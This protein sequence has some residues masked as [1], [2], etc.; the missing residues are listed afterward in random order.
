MEIPS[1]N[2]LIEQSIIKNWE[3]DALTDYKGATLQ[4]RDVARKIEKLHIIF[5][6][7]G[8]D[9]GDK[10]A[11]CGRNSSNWAVVFLATLTYGAVAVPILHEFMPDQVHN[12]VNHSEAKLLFVGDMVAPT[13]QE[14]EMP[15]LEGILFIP[16]F[17]VLVSRSEKLTYAREHL[18]E[19]FGH[20]Y[21]KYFRQ[22]HINYYKEESP[23][24]LLLINYT[25]GTTGFSKG[26]MIP[27]RALWSNYD[28][29]TGVLGDKVSRGDN[30]ISI[31]PMAHM[32]GMMFEFLFEFLIGCHIYFLTRIPSPAI[33]AQAFA[34]VKP[35]VIIAVPLVIEKIIRKKV[36]P[37][38]QNNLMKLLLNMPVVSKKVNQK[39]CEEVKNAFGGRFYEIIVGG[40]AFN[41]EIENFLHKINFPYTVGYGTTECAPIIAYSDYNDFVPGSCG[42]AV[43]HMQVEIE[44]SDPQNIP[45]EII[46]KG[47]NVMLGYYK[48]E[49]ATKQVLDSNGWYHT[50]DLG[51]MDKDGNIFIKGRSKNM[52]LGSNGQNI[53]PEEIEDKLNSLALVGESIVLQREE[54]LVALVHPDMEEAES[55][56]FSMDDIQKVMTQNLQ[57]LNDMMPGYSKVSDIILHEEE[58]E[59][60][61]KKSIKRYLYK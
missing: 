33:I 29:A 37:K 30:I 60:T 48:N 44:S 32:Y 31:L 36:F 2:S 11:I 39:I 13:I 16:D 4:Y 22:E 42:K 55:M 56:G 41:Q 45:G 9:K 20:K 14:E 24:E 1:F 61:P 28:F 23:E 21:P 50:G 40:A 52:L 3:L 54:K 8:I 53:Y 5:Q 43:V 26:V 57:T 25:S 35:A 34:E 46:V 18:N 7:S 15:H 19:I 27:A 59:K 49:E 58:F 6:N 17:S 10:I 47:L 51:I 12:I 38:I